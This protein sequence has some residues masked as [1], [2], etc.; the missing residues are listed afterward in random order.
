MDIP[1]LIA[2][3]KLLDKKSVSQVSYLYRTELLVAIGQWQSWEGTF[4]AIAPLSIIFFP[5][6]TISSIWCGGIGAVWGQKIKKTKSLI[7]MRFYCPY[8]TNMTHNFHL[9]CYFKFFGLKLIPIPLNHVLL[10]ANIYN[11]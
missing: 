1:T 4:D 3:N 5:I 7:I 9:L 2:E 6:I 11:F 8:L 10:I